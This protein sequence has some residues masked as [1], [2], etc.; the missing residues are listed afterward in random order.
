MKAI[1]LPASFVLNRL[2]L[3]Q[4]FVIIT[5]ISVMP[6][7]VIAHEFSGLLADNTAGNGDRLDITYINNYIGFSLIFVFYSL[8]G[9]YYSLKTNI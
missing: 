4:K 9:L 6:L 1:F 5:L 3:L 7:F 8:A 2:G